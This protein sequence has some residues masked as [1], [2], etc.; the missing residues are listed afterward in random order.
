MPHYTI[1]AHLIKREGA[2]SP[3]GFRR[4]SPARKSDGP[5]ALSAIAAGLLHPASAACSMTV[6]PFCGAAGRS[7]YDAGRGLLGW[8]EPI[9]SAQ[10]ERAMVEY[11][12]AFVGIAAAKSRNAIAIA[13][14][15]R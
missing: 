10:G 1:V 2:H 11:S 14:A 7:S 3:V 9:S 6:C 15:G 12:E 8:A 5:P 13:L 4:Q